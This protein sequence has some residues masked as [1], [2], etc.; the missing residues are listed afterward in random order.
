MSVLPTSKQ[1]PT[2]FTFAQLC[3]QQGFLKKTS[4]K[5]DFFKKSLYIPNICSN[6]AAQNH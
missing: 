4:N 6:F 5:F 2:E 1:G 3:Q